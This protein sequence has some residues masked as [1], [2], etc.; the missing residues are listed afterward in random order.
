MERAKPTDRGEG[1]K[2]LSNKYLIFAFRFLVGFIFIIAAIPKIADPSSFAKSIQAYQL[3]PTI[4]INITALV[5]PWVELL[6]GIF[7]IVGVLLRGSAI[8]SAGLFAAFSIII[9]VSLIR[10]LTID[11]GCFGPNSSPLSWMR[12]WEDIGLLLV[13]I[14]IFHTSKN[15]L[16]YAKKNLSS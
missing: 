9:A 3:I 2:I 11:C 6:I 1:M 5:I 10:G 14:L 7:L 4:L 16:I 12:F 8:L 13:S 15:Q